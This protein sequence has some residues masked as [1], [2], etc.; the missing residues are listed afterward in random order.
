MTITVPRPWLLLAV[1]VTLASLATAY[2]VAAD[3][4]PV[5]PPLEYVPVGGQPE[6]PNI[7]PAESAKARQVLTENATFRRLAEQSSW[8][9]SAEVPNTRNGVKVGMGVVVGFDAPVRLS[10]PWTQLFCRGTESVEFSLDYEDISSIGVVFDSSGTITSLMPLM[11]PRT[12]FDE[13]QFN[14]LQTST[15]A[16]PEGM[17]DEER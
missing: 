10:G 7:T 15:P 16:C 17:E 2:A 13:E 3:S 9:V 1:V 6:L 8:Q 5:D 11:D 12:T 4:G 14:E